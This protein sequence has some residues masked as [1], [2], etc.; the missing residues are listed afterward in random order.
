MGLILVLLVL[1]LIF[2]GA[3]FAVHLLWFVAIVFFIAWLIGLAVGSGRRS[4]A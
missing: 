2:A 1:A 3:G 4:S